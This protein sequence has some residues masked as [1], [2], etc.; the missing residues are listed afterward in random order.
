MYKILTIAI[1]AKISLLFSI[2]IGAIIYLVLIHL[3]DI[4]NTKQ[5]QTLSFRQKKAKS[6][7][8]FAKEN[9]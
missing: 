8:K 6:N 5:L 1:N 7:R 9:A 4:L 3:F 2:G